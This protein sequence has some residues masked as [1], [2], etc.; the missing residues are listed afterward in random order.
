MAVSVLPVDQRLIDID[1]RRFASVEKALVELITNCDDSY[2]RLEGKGLS[3][4]GK[5]TVS[6][7]RYLNGAVIIVSDAAEGMTFE[8]VRSVLSYGGAHS[9]LALGKKGGRGYFGRGMKQA[10]YG[11]GYGWIESIYESRYSRYDLF[12]SDEGGYM[13]DD[14]D[15]DRP[16]L[17]DDYIRM[18]IPEGSNGTQITIVID[19]IKTKIPRF[20]SMLECI[21]N[22]IYLRD[23]LNRRKVE[24]INLNRP[25]KENRGVFL[26]YK[27]PKGE[28]LIGPDA[29]GGF[30]FQGRAYTFTLT[31]KRAKD[32]D[33][34]IKG[35]QRTNG[36][37]VISGTAVLDCQFFQFENQ[38]GTEFLFGTVSCDA[39][40]EKLIEGYSVISDEREGL[41]LKDPFVAAFAA[42]VSKRIVNI[43]KSEQLRLSYIVD[44]KISRNMKGRI[45]QVIQ[46]M[47]KIAIDDL[48]ILITHDSGSDKYIANYARRPDALRFS[49]PFYYRKAF[50]PFS[51]TMITDKNQLQE[52]DIIT[53]SYDLPDSIKI[54]PV[55]ESV[56]LSHMQGED[57]IIWTAEGSEIGAKG[58][59]T[60]ET[61]QF[62]ASCDIVIAENAS[63][64]GYGNPSPKSAGPGFVYNYVDMFKGYELRNLEGTAERAV[65]SPEERLIIINTEAP[66]VRLYVN[67]QGHFKEGA[68]FLLAELLL[69][70][71][72]DEFARH[73]V[74][75]TEKKGQAGAYRQAKNEL[76]RRYGVVIHSILLGE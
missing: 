32:T 10:V 24:M 22:N 25:K 36:L 6:Y 21:S 71:I 37:L 1:S 50:S 65:Y 35:D 49:T 3:V 5:I 9:L 42:A 19:N 2:S 47:N 74:D 63:G 28:I 62:S 18:N 27:E 44:P 41:N 29:E 43:V 17:K 34:V 56:A 16:A 57:R 38:L 58:R 59:I 53:F 30:N 61:G 48:E 70:V 26:Q 4:A 60:A 7:E 15:G 55:L 14:S 54:H 69:D 73:F 67:G 8:R 31:L 45:E 68:R 39:L 23:I 76:I 72:T 52:K 64:K 33:L 11:L 20:S 51:V 66:T 12:H 75:R 46:A 40:A 13:F